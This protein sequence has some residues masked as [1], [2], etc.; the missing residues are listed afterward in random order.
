MR[1]H[2]MAISVLSAIAAVCGCSP[3]VTQPPT[4]AVNTPAST[5]PTTST[6]AAVTG[7][8]SVGCPCGLAM[9][10]KE[11]KEGFQRAHPGVTFIPHIKNISPMTRE[12]RD[13]KVSLD[14]FLS[15]GEK[16]AGALVTAGVVSGEPV[17]FL[18]QS[19]QLLVQKGNPLGIHSLEDLARPEVGTVAV[20]SANLTIGDAGEKALRSAGVWQKLSDEGKII[21]FDQPAQA[22]EQVVNKKADATFIYSQCSAPSW[23][24]GDPERSVT[25]KAE[26][27][28]TVPED[29]YGGMRAAAVVLKTAKNPA[30]ARAFIDFLTTPEAQEAITK[31]G[32]GKLAG[33]AAAPQSK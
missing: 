32:Y 18:R 24:E 6:A 28:L 16:E 22:K 27:V 4:D 21:R 8:L 25:G 29:S 10:Y 23:V 33:P 11:L 15:L 30:L 31:W 9:A 26:V 17:P 3:K 2:H 14:V 20:C 12:L 7:T 19:M 5:A 1:P 13:G